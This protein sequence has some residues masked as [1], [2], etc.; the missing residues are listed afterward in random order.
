[1]VHIPAFAYA[2]PEI[3][4]EGALVEDNKWM[5]HGKLGKIRPLMFDVGTGNWIVLLKAEGEGILQRHHHPSSVTAFTLDGAWGY[6][7]YDWTA[8][9][10]S[11]VY[12]P[13]G[14]I[15]TLFIHPSERKMLVLFH[16]QGPVVYLDDD[17]QV[18][19]Y[20]DAFVHLDR[21]SRHCKEQGI[22][23]EWVRSLIR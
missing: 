18:V 22:G 1:M 15:H 3:F 5:P 20:A 11:F 19:D 4:Q 10:G 17:N 9:T 21:Y 2:R 14:H 12:E 6:K 16:S 8:R 7:E 23:E 13:P